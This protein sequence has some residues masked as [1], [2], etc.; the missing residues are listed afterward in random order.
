MRNRADVKSQSRMKEIK[1][2]CEKDN[3]TCHMC[4]VKKGE[5]ERSR[6]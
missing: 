3:L 2:K 4:H 1:D 5:R 6:D